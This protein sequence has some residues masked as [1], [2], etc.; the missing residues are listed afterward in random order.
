MSENILNLNSANFDKTVKSADKLML[1]DFWAPWCGPCRALGPV[2]EELATEFDKKVQVCKVNVDENGE[3]AAKFNVRGIPA[4]FVL[5]NGKVVDQ[6]VGLAAKND[7]KSK[8]E[9]HL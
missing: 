4:M 6:M 2:L 1:V 8:L 3:L 7:I 5:K 9:A